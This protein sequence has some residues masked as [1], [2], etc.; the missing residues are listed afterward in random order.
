MHESEPFCKKQITGRPQLSAINVLMDNVNVQKLFLLDK[1]KAEYHT[2][3]VY[4]RR[5][6]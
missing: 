3:L 2:Y 4:A 1:P 5:F 6:S